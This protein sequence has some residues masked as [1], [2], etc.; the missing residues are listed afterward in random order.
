ML[1]LLIDPIE[2]PNH[3][4]VACGLGLKNRAHNPAYNSANYS[5]RSHPYNSWL[6]FKARLVACYLI[7]VGMASRAGT[8]SF[9]QQGRRKDAT[10][11]EEP[12]AKHDNIDI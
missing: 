6:L 9:L 3:G 12:I 5:W 7:V 4:V 10:P 1:A 2:L 11:V 8:K